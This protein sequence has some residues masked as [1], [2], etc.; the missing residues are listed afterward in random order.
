MRNVPIDEQRF[1]A[2]TISL[3]EIVPENDF[4]SG[5]QKKTPDGVPIWKVRILTRDGD[6]PT[7][8][9]EITEVKV[10]HLT[11]PKLDP[12]MKPLFGGLVGLVWSSNTGGGLSFRAESIATSE[13]PSVK[14]AA[15]KAAA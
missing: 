14:R 6:D 7:R 1:A 3:L 15:E 13:R 12:A 2:K 5:I 4:D 8:R 10:P 9:P 11:E